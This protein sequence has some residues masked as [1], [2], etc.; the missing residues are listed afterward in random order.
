MAY[1]TG[2]EY[3][4]VERVVAEVFC[5][6]GF[7]EFP[8]DEKMVCAKLGVRLVP[9]KEILGDKERLLNKR[10]EWGFFVKGSKE[11]LPTIY[12]DNGFLKMHQS[13]RFTVFHE[14]KH[15]V[16]EDT[17][18][19]QDD[20]AD[21]FARCFMCPPAYFLLRGVSD[22][23]EL[24]E[25]CDISREMAKNAYN[26]IVNRKAKYGYKLHDYEIDMVRLIDE[27]LLS[28]VEGVF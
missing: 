28:K 24:E 18:E 17:D 21:H 23:S 16:F 22:P 7:R 19:E 13:V 1:R 4:E 11:N 20:L 9:Y 25:I 5:D 26:Q 10:S 2:R 6:Y 12:Y 8:L 27:K 15:F 3:D 14:L